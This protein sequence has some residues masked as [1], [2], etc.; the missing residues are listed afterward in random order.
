MYV[1]VKHIYIDICI[2]YIFIY[3]Y[4]YVGVFGD[5]VYI[6]TVFPKTPTQNNGYLY[7]DGVNFD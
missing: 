1:Y 6:Y 7:V 4:L 3:L 5:T 2:V